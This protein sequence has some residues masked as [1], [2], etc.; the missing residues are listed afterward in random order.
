[1]N[2]A[3]DWLEQAR[4]NLAHA[5]HSRDAGDYA[6]ACFAAHQAAEAAVKALHLHR[7]QIVWGHSVGSLLES[8]PEAARPDPPFIQRVAV[9]DRFYIP[10]RYPDAHP[11]GPAA[12]H[13]TLTDAE[14]AIALAREVVNYCAG[15]GLED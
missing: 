10:T 7:G 3:R 13:Y 5:E 14:Q 15:Q 9:L 4:A 6:W 1:M 11:A 2:R 12:K 8:L